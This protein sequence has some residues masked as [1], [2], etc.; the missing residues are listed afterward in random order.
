VT[1]AGSFHRAAAPNL[2]AGE[3]H[4]GRR[5]E[6]ADVEGSR[7]QRHQ[8]HDREDP[9][10]SADDIASNP[11]CTSATI[12]PSVTLTDSGRPSAVAAASIVWWFCFT[13]VPF[14][15]VSLEDAQHLPQ[16]RN[17]AEDRHVK[18]HDARGNVAAYQVRDTNAG[19]QVFVTTSCGSTA[20]V[21]VVAS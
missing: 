16:G 3:W 5:R 1:V 15:K 7:Q 12:S 4:P 6:H 8:S 18:F 14:L 17:K 19:R 9:S 20:Q 21:Q 10:R 11:P 13:A 2:V